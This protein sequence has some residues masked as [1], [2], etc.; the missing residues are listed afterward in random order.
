GAE[1]WKR[2]LRE[3]VRLKK[4]QFYFSEVEL[5]KENN[6]LAKPYEPL[7]AIGIPLFDEADKLAGMLVANVDFSKISSHFLS[8][9]D[10]DEDPNSFICNRKGYYLLNT[11]DRDKEFAFEFS[12]QLL[13]QNDFPGLEA[14]IDDIASQQRNAGENNEFFDGMFNENIFVLQK[15]YLNPENSSQYVISGIYSAD[16]QLKARARQMLFNFWIFSG[17]T[18]VMISIVVAV[19]IGILTKKISV[20]TLAAENIAAGNR[21]V[22]IPVFRGN[23]EV[24]NLSVAFKTMFDRL[25][26][27]YHKLGELNV[28]L[29][30]KIEEQTAS[31]KA[32]SQ[33]LTDSTEET[34]RHA[35]LAER[36]TMHKNQFMANISHDIRTPL[37]G[38]IGMTQV[39]AKMDLNESQKECVDDILASGELLRSL[40][41]DLLNF[42]AIQSGDFTVENVGFKL[43]SIFEAIINSVKNQAKDK[44]LCLNLEYAENIPEVVVSDP[45]R[46]KQIITNLLVNALKFTDQGG[47][48]V[49]ASGDF[50]SDS[51]FK[52]IIKIKDTGMGIPEDKLNK[53]F[54]HFVQ[55]DSSFSRK[56]SGVGIGLAVCKQLIN[57]LGGDITVDS[58]VG[59]G[60]CF[61]VSLPL[62]LAADNEVAVVNEKVVLNWRR[63]PKVLVAED[64]IINQKIALNFL[65][66]DG[67]EIEIAS[68]GLQAVEKFKKGGWDMVLMDVQMPNLDGIEATR[69]IRQWESENAL[70]KVPILALT[71]SAM[72]PEQKICLA[73]GMDDLLFKPLTGNKL[74]MALSE[75]LVVLL[76]KEEKND[77]IILKNENKTKEVTVDTASEEVSGTQNMIKI[78]F[79]NKVNFNRKDALSNFTGNETLLEEMIAYFKENLN[80]NLQKLDIAIEQNDGTSIKSIAHL[81]KGEAGTLGAEKINVVAARLEIAG[82]DGN[83]E[84]T[85]AILNVFKALVE[86]FN[87]AG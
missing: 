9:V 85:K 1:D 83:I 31:F 4:G 77:S 62:E 87:P 45:L 17:I 7:I 67:C 15:L 64:S 51:M 33:K 74:E 38:I 3:G 55:L 2:Y 48:S 73:A 71:A 82:K 50:F 16:S 76:A 70:D 40:I 86:E 57:K 21:G 59:E 41:D 5:K 46:I 58:K 60:S 13:L 66:Q 23:D 47:V 26:E 79:G 61:T 28:S 44:K 10:G 35:S 29:T 63:A 80:V 20:L 14:M 52:L 54:D 43:K 65:T 6:K 42:P 36:A 8:R 18:F 34:K 32:I 69:Q 11:A 37:N 30:S 81:L 78:D 39:L 75:Y 27:A 84:D 12:N 22:A 68:D 19:I 25:Q 53:I 24:A 49:E 56:H 72:L